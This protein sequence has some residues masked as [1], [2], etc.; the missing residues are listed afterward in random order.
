MRDAD[1]HHRGTEAQRIEMQNSG[2]RIQKPEGNKRGLVRDRLALPHPGPLP[3]ERVNYGPDGWRIL[4]EPSSA[5][6]TSKG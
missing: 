2:V 3:K 5:Q 6:F 1:F 4:D